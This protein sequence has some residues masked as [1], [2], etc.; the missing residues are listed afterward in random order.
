MLGSWCGCTYRSPV[1]RV[2]NSV[3]HTQAAFLQRYATTLSVR[4]PSMSLACIAARGGH[5]HL[6]S[7]Q[8]LLALNM[9]LPLDADYLQRSRTCAMALLTAWLVAL[10]TL[11]DVELEEELD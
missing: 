8:T 3:Q 5:M 6:H 2:K 10:D 11:V 9:Q 4:S 7:S 1:L